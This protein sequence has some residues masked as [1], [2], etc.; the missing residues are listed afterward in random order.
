MTTKNASRCSAAPSFSVA[1]AEF[2]LAH[3]FP[4]P[5]HFLLK[6]ARFFFGLSRPFSRS[7]YSG[8]ILGVGGTSSN[9]PRP[10]PSLTDFGNS[11]RLGVRTVT[12]FLADRRS[13]SLIVHSRF[14][15]M[16]KR[17]E[18]ATAGE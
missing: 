7:R 5:S 9:L 15:A 8:L 3:P 12:T 14:L 17:V 11:D 6:L 13:V 10:P 4:N 2:P 1:T 16:K 18:V